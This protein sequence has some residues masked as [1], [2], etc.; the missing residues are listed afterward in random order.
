MIGAY[1]A[2]VRALW[3]VLK[4]RIR[5]RFLDKGGPPER[6]PERLGRDE[7]PRG[8]APV[9]WVHAVSVGEMMSALPL[10]DALLD[11]RPE[12]QVLLT[13][14]T[15]S[16]AEL[17]AKRLPERACHRFAPLDHPRIVARFLDHWQPER[18]IFIES[19]IWPA[20]IDALAQRSIPL[21]LVSARLTERS[22]ARWQRL[23]RL[24]RAVFGAI[25]LILTQDE[26]SAAR[27]RALGA[28]E[29]AVGGSLK[30]A[31]GRLPVDEALLSKMNAAI[32]TRPVW[33]AA[34]THP[35]EEEIIAAA[36][37]AVRAAVPDALCILAPRH[38]ERGDDIAAMLCD[39]PRRSDGAL[40]GAEDGLYLADSYGEMGTWFSLAP[41]VFMGGSLV[42]GVGGHNPLEAA[43]FGAAIL[44]GPHFANA[45]ADFDR[46]IQAGAALEV[47]GE[48][49][50]ADA[51]LR[52]L[53]GDAAQAMG[54]IAETKAGSP[55][56][57]REIAAR[58]LAL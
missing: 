51:V 54:R 19:E 52:L 46:L 37:R 12:A 50:L 6:W 56:I 27:A 21:A 33:I 9:I 53:T 4:Q 20:Q 1:R 34:S 47:Q 24:G 44:T 55:D 22:M 43:G 36:H 23:G 13:T 8:D 39:P 40:P 16:S 32:G 41:L 25:P 17:A 18:A 7:S 57:A 11:A 10:I 15:A 30:L 38:V 5:Q 14:G 26:D 42:A 2:A 58:C 45:Q 35:G 48:A 49:D 29:V 28:P 3:P 31:G